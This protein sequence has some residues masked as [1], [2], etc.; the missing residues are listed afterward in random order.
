VIGWIAT[1]GL[2]SVGPSPAWVLAGVIVLVAVSVSVLALRA[3][4]RQPTSDRFWRGWIFYVNPDDP[5]LFVP[6]RF[7]IG[8]TINFAHPWSSVALAVILLLAVVPIT[9][10]ALVLHHLGVR[11]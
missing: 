10:A 4:R 5:A 7:G 9:V 3:P 8:Y 11:H 1:T 2:R 6:K